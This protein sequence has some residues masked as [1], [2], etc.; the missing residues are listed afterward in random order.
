M[1]SGLFE[2][3]YGVAIA[4]ITMTADTSL[5][6]YAGM[7]NLSAMAYTSWKMMAPRTAP[8]ARN[9]IFLLALMKIPPI[10]REARAMVTRP[11]PMS[12]LT[13][14]WLCASR[15][16]ERAVSDPDMHSP[17]VVVKAGLMELDLTMAGLFPVARIASP[18]FVLRNRDRKTITRATATR[19]PRVLYRPAKGVF[20]RSFLN[21]VK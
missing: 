10:R 13:D 11:D 9:G 7:L 12:A 18:S 5:S 8:T 14:F 1:R 21:N 2:L 16:P 6:M 3:R 20:S 15:H 4:M 19:A 17:T